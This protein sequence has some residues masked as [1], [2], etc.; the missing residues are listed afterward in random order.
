MVAI[1]KTTQIQEPSSATVN[2]ALDTSGG[3]AFGNAIQVGG[4]AGTSG[5]YLKSN[6]SGA[7]PSWATLS[8][9]G[10]LIRAPQILTSGTSYTTP[11]NCTA[12]YVEAVGGGGAGGS[13][14][15]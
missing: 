4:S 1:L 5:Q 6:G 7:S 14:N 13:A 8:S 2:L 10:A 3:V 15:G 9:S 12:I 11:S